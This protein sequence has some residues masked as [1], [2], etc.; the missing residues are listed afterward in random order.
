MSVEDFTYSLLP[1]GAR[2]VMGKLYNPTSQW[3]RNAQI[4]IGLYDGDNRLV[5]TMS[6]VVRNIE[7]G[8]FMPFR[9]T[10]DEDV[11]IQGA[12]VRSVLVP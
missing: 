8:Q 3:I 11:D 1:G 7:P 12:K 9:K 10:V 6:V 2:V 5:T 4:Q